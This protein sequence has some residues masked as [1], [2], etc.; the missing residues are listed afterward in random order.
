MNRLKSL[1]KAI[2]PETMI[3]V[4]KRAWEKVMLAS[5]RAAVK[6][7]GLSEWLVRHELLFPDISRQYTE[8]TLDTEILRFKVRAVQAFQVRWR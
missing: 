8:H 4:L 6:E 7:Q 5:L 3:V 2:L 1:L